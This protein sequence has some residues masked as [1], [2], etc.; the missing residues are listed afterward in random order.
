M[1]A[2]RPPAVSPRLCKVLLTAYT[3]APRG[4]PRP[5][6]AALASIFSSRLAAIAFVAIA[7]VV[8]LTGSAPASAVA[9]RTGYA[10]RQVAVTTRP[11]AALTLTEP[12]NPVA[13]QSSSTVT[14]ESLLYL[15]WVAGISAILIVRRRLRDHAGRIAR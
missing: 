7:S 12:N 13:R 10:P 11:P 3:G 5:G 1:G 2:G 9:D 6:T 14:P 4:R 8:V 15:L